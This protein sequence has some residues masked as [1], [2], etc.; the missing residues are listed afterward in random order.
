MTSL[1]KLLRVDSRFFSPRDHS[2]FILGLDS[3][4]FPTIMLFENRI[5]FLASPERVGKVALEHHMMPTKGS[6]IEKLI[7]LTSNESTSLLKGSMSG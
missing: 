4:F 3:P 2:G 1:R 5:R 6:P 7:I